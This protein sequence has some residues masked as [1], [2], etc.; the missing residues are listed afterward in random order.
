MLE[1]LED[2][3]KVELT[4]GVKTF[5]MDR[6]EA[7]LVSSLKNQHVLKTHSNGIGFFNKFL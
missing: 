7:A 6:R 5:L 3:E 2:A 4:D 1:Y